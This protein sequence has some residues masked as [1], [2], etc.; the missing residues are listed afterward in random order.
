MPIIQKIIEDARSFGWEI[1]STV[2]V[3]IGRKNL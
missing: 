1:S 3:E 2:L